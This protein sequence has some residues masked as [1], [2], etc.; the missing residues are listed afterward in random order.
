M[1]RVSAIYRVKPEQAGS[2][3]A[4]LSDFVHAIRENEPQ[5]EYRVF[6]SADGRTYLHLMAFPN[7]AAQAKHESAAYTKTFLESLEPRCEE[8]PSFMALTLVAGTEASAD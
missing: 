1:I 8:A 5:A 2:I 4:A 7:K 3:D 6:K